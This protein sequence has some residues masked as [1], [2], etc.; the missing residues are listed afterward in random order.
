MGAEV[1]WVV[2]CLLTCRSTR[3][4]PQFHEL[5]ASLHPRCRLHRPRHLPH[6]P[7]RSS[8]RPRSTRKPIFCGKNTSVGHGICLSEPVL[9]QG[10][11]PN[12]WCSFPPALELGF[13]ENLERSRAG[14]AKPRVVM[15]VWQSRNGSELVSGEKLWKKQH[16]WRICRF[17]LR[18]KSSKAA[19]LLQ[20]LQ[21]CPMAPTHLFSAEGTFLGG[22]ILML[23]S[24]SPGGR[25]MTSSRNSSMPA[26]RSSLSRAL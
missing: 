20:H 10:P 21:T 16:F 24:H 15:Q 22:S 11:R 6:R 26:I 12:P 9:M 1:S 13:G 25:T 3:V 14:F 5:R 7:C 8:A 17:F 23:G 18:M 2:G 4:L 19:V